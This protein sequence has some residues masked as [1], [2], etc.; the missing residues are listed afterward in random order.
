MREYS[1]I[2]GAG[3]VSNAEDQ[4]L[5]RMISGR[6]LEENV[7]N[8]NIERTDVGEAASIGVTKAFIVILALA[9]VIL[10]VLGP[11]I[12]DI[13]MTKETP[14]IPDEYRFW[15]L[16]IAGYVLA[17][18]LFIF[19]FVL[20]RLIC[21]IELGEVFVEPN[22]RA[23]RRLSNLVFL[24]CII[25]FAVGITC[26]YMVFI[27]TV[28]TAFVTPIISVIQHAFARAVAM[29]DELDLTV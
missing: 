1:C 19:L 15:V 7:M 27:I 16:L 20:Y 5:H 26:T 4:T 18:I 29:K 22:V 13:V 23:L 8:K 14:L 21:R 11:K 28:T 10:C 17:I 9:A 3:N 2:S 24:V 6:I 12:V 25:T